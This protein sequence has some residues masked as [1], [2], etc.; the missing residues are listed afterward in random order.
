MKPVYLDTCAGTPLD[1]RVLDEMMPFFSDNFYNPSALYKG[2]RDTKLALET[3]RAS[4]SR[5]IG[6]R[7]S[8]IIFTAG[9]TRIR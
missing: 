7:P 2:A 6:A 9:G 5:T 3:A 4:V 1:P 8:E